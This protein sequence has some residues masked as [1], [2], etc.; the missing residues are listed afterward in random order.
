[1]ARTDSPSEAHAHDTASINT[2]IMVMGDLVEEAEYEPLP[3]LQ[4]SPKDT[5]RDGGGGGRREGMSDRREGCHRQRD[6]ESEGWKQK[7]MRRGVAD[8]GR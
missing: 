2:C 8:G 4:V 3:H 5:Q 6:L 1:R 7:G